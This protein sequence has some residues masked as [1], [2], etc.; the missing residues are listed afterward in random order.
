MVKLATAAI[1][2]LIIFLLIA[3]AV[4]F[5][6]LPKE[7]EHSK[8]LKTQR[9]VKLVQVPQIEFAEPQEELGSLSL[10][11]IACPNGELIPVSSQC[12]VPAL[13]EEQVIN[14][15]ATIEEPVCGEN[16]VTYLNPCFGQQAGVNFVPGMCVETGAQVITAFNISNA[17]TTLGQVIT[18]GIPVVCTVFVNTS[19]GEVDNA[20]LY[21]SG[22][23]YRVRGVY[24]DDAGDTSRIDIVQFRGVLYVWYDDTPDSKWYS[25]AANLPV[26]SIPIASQRLG[27]TSQASASSLNCK[28]REFSNRVFQVPPQQVER[29]TMLELISILTS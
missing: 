18:S 28:R 2:F 16:N 21:I 11:V 17:T 4:A 24:V 29:K 27:L 25:V 13:Q 26:T 12:T 14:C 23:N 10:E 1:V 8:R 3:G 9:F 6:S 5:L 15:D 20:T 22:N 7:V 19:T